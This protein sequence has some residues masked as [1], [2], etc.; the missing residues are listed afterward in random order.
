M[1]CFFVLQLRVIS[2]SGEAHVYVNSVLVCP[3]LL[4]WFKCLLQICNVR[5][6]IDSVTQLTVTKNGSQNITL[7]DVAVN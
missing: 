7:I 1:Q 3:K 5:D 2:L 4:N 6:D